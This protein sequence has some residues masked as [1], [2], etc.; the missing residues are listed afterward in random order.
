MITILR[1]TATVASF[2]IFIGIFAWA[3]SHRRV[4]AFEDAS[5]L[6]FEQD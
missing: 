1:I 5:R 6:P 2:I 4:Q 3:W